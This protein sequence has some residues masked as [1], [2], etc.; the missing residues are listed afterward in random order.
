MLQA[1][2]GRTGF[3]LKSKHRNL[4]TQIT[5]CRACHRKTRHLRQSVPTTRFSLRSF[6]I[7]KSNYPKLELETPWCCSPKVLYT[8]ML[9]NS[10]N[11]LWKNDLHKD[12]MEIQILNSQG[13][14]VRRCYTLVTQSPTSAWEP[15]GFPAA[16]VSTY[17]DVTTNSSCRLQRPHQLIKLRVL[18]SRN[19]TGRCKNWNERNQK[20][21]WVDW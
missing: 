5:P 21:E 15:R 10:V 14:A 13:T 4:V 12:F 7:S 18:M 17:L 16:S 8:S 1:A 9:V 6:E 19:L 11:C 2:L 20:I 3:Y